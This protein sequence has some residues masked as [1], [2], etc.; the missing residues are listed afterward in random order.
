VGVLTGFGG[1]DDLDEADLVL[2]SVVELVQW[3]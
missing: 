3:L 2:E 1:E